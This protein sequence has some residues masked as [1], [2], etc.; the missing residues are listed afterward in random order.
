MTKKV[1]SLFSNQKDAEEAVEALAASNLEEADIHTVEKWNAEMESEP[2]VMPALHP[3]AGSTGAAL[4][5]TTGLPDL[6]FNNEAKQF[7]KRNL[8]EGGVL[9]V[10]EP[11]DDV[12]AAEIKKILKEQG[13][14]VLTD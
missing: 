7:F 1:Y 3:G 6:D 8:S 4:P 9:V 10:V 14:R 2:M 11:S 5:I 13:G 12:N